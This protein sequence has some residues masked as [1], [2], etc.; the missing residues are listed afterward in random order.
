MKHT[1]ATSAAVVSILL[2]LTCSSAAQTAP[3]SPAAAP[4]TIPGAAPKITPD[5]KATA[6][7]T[8]AA[9]GAPLEG[10]NSYTE[11]QAKQRVID[12]GFSNVSA[13][14]K[15]DKGIWRGTA[16]KSGKQASIAVD[17]KG[18]VVTAN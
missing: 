17:F 14:A 1:L 16:T 10:A 12:S 18:N 4:T 3:A 6:P 7:A 8:S 15:D 11:S 9:V 5:V 2:A 13:L